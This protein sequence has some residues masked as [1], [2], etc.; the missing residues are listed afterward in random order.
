MKFT[1]KNN[2]N[3]QDFQ[4]SAQ[5][6]LE[7][8]L[9]V[10]APIIVDL[11]SPEVYN[12][13]HLAGANNLPA[14]FLEANLMQL[15]PFAP[16][17]VYADQDQE[18]IDAAKLLDQNGFDEVRWVEG[19]Y[20]ALN[21]ALRM[22]KNQIFLDDLPKEEWSAKIELVLDQKVRPALASDGGGLV[23]NKIDGDKVYVN[24][25]GSCS[26]CASSTTGTLKFIQS[27]LRISLNHA[28]EVIPV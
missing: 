6:C 8:R 2:F 11:R 20:A 19:G 3:A 15:P 16:V 7:E 17:F 9:T 12:Q 18:A 21:Q 5:R 25:Q 1:N 22:D 10:P 28:I 14:E 27:Q 4:I 13:G 23:L 26:G 24:Y